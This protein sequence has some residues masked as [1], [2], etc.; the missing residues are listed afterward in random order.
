[1]P[2]ERR[3]CYSSLFEV[4]NSRRIKWLSAGRSRSLL[5]LS[6]QCPLL[7]NGLNRTSRHVRLVPILL[8]KSVAPVETAKN[9]AETNHFET[10]YVIDEADPKKTIG[11]PKPR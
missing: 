8:Q 3:P 11:Q 2:R 10:V 1:M 5:P 7:S 4:L 6:R 9:L